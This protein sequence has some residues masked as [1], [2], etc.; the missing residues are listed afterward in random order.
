MKNSKKNT[1]KKTKNTVNNAMMS[2]YLYKDGDTWKFDD[3]IHGI[4][5]EPFVLGM[6]E[7]ISF[8]VADSKV[9]N[10]TITF[11]HNKF[12]GCYELNLLEEESNGGWYFD[13]YSEKMGWL[14]PV[15]RIYMNY[16]PENIYFLVQ[17]DSYQQSTPT[18]LQSVLN[19]I[20]SFF[21]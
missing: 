15:T 14:C 12:P 20:K 16:I 21:K 18:I 1:T 17:N 2:L 13:P 9:K 8:Y 10:T 19:K 7:M 11:S 3:P 5:A 6:S 4:K